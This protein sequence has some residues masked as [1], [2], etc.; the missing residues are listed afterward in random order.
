M[1]FTTLGNKNSPA[2]ILIHGMLMSGEDPLVFGKHLAD[3]YYVICPTLDGHG[4]D[5]SELESAEQEG[6]NIVAYLKKNGI[7]DIALIQGS[8][9]GAEVAL[10]VRNECK[11]RGVNVDH[12]FFDGGPF[13]DFHPMKRFFMTLVFIRL[14]KIFDNEPD[15]ALEKLNK[16]MFVKFV[17]KDKLKDFEPIFIQMTKKRHAFTHKTVEGMVKTC[18]NCI[19]PQFT[20]EE[21]GTFVFFFS[22]EEPARDSKP[23]LKKAYPYAKYRDIRGYAHCGLQF[24]RPEVYAK[25]LKKVIRD[26]KI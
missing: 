8:S 20:K 25:I 5:G 4:D 14:T 11:R 24:N 7:T 16:N 17:A 15:K 18:Y 22:N 6:R 2:V 9:M 10:A 23:R 19:L 13:F 12:C 3:D 21:Q 26:E 1:Q